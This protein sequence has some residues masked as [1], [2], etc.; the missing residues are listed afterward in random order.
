MRVEA[1]PAVA[2][3]PEDI[4]ADVHVVAARPRRRQALVQAL[5]F[6][7]IVQEDA[8]ASIEKASGQRNTHRIIFQ[9]VAITKASYKIVKGIHSKLELFLCLDFSFNV[10]IKKAWSSL[11]FA[12]T[13]QTII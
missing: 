13:R 5:L 1:S 11:T 7:R 12:T 4:D 8:V 3:T 10:M 6:P 2:V 9:D